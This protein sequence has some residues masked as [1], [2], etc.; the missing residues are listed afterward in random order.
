[1]KEEWTIE[2]HCSLKISDDQRKHMETIKW[3]ILGPRGSGRTFM[4]AFGFVNFAYH[5]GGG[6]VNIW[7]HSYY[8]QGEIMKQVRLICDRSDFS[9]LVQYE[10]NRRFRIV[11]KYWGDEK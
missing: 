9:D 10:G 4:L 5:R 1:M 11:N 2:E 3:L 7:N 6:W 8:F